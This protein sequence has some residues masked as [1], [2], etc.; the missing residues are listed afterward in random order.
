M[1]KIKKEFFTLKAN[2]DLCDALINRQE[3]G[4]NISKEHLL[5]EAGLED[6]E[7]LTR[8]LSTWI[9]PPDSVD[10]AQELINKLNKV[11]SENRL[12]EIYQLLA[13]PETD[14][15]KKEELTREMNRILLE[16]RQ[17]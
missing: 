10:A 4:Q 14:E 11:K 9:S 6:A 13:S 7:V 8:L 16:K 15:A 5:T 3:T 12:G 2:I 17:K 1:K